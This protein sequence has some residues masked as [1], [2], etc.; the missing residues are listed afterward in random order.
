[1]LPGSVHCDLYSYPYTAVVNGA[2]QHC[3]VGMRAQ[4]DFETISKQ[5]VLRLWRESLTDRVSSDTIILPEFITDTRFSQRIREGIDNVI[6][7]YA[8]GTHNSMLEAMSQIFSVF[9]IMT[10]AS[11]SAANGEFSYSDTAYCAKATAYISRNL[12]RQITVGQIASELNI[13]VGYLSRIFKSVTGQSIISYVNKTKMEQAKQL[14]RSGLGASEIS[15]MLGIS[16]EK[17]FCRLF[18]KY[19]GVTASRYRS[20]IGLV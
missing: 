16:D 18:K 14:I 13:S 17:Y 4:Y 19:N 1:M 11:V 10:E 20:Q 3:T 5:E 8:L 15:A 2:H 9:S 12:E 6:R 7:L